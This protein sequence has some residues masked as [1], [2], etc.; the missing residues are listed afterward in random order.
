[1]KTDYFTK[2]ENKYIFNLSLIFWHLFI[3]LGTLVIIASLFVLAYTLSPTFKASVDSVVYPPEVEV[4]ISDLDLRDRVPANTQTTTQTTTRTQRQQ[5]QQ[6]MVTGLSMAGYNEY[7]SALDSLKAMLPNSSNEWEAVYRIDIAP[8]DKAK[9]IYYGKDPKYERKVLV[10]DGI[11]GWLDNTFELVKTSSYLERAEL[12]RGYIRIIKSI[13]NEFNRRTTLSRLQDVVRQQK[14]VTS[15]LS[16]LNILQRLSKKVPM[17]DSIY[18]QEPLWVID[19]FCKGQGSCEEF[20]QMVEMHVGKFNDSQ[21]IPAFYSMLNNYS[22]FNNLTMQS[23]LTGKYGELLSK[24]P[25]LKQAEGLDQYYAAYIRKNAERSQQIAQ[26]EKEYRSDVN[27]AEADYKNKKNNKDK[28]RMKSIMAAMAG[29][30]F[31]SVLAILLV[32]LS[33][34]RSVRKI[35][36]RMDFKDLS[37]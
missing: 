20:I 31:I 5:V 21:Q 8:E 34:Q 11:Q 6:P 10:S 4:T 33:I 12:I 25:D 16:R 15:G 17:N 37:E 22:M 24:V 9:Y 2:V 14:N 13:H 23:E 29:V 36:E 18:R 27:Q 19:R 3:L 26:L 7:L 1:M 32:F 35:E 28:W 30:A